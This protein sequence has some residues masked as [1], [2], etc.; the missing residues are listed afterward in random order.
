MIH[1]GIVDLLV[2]RQNLLLIRLID[3]NQ[4]RR[5]SMLQKSTSRGNLQHDRG[6]RRTCD[7]YRF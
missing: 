7:W 2:V 1:M 3:M 4:L 5:H 6:V